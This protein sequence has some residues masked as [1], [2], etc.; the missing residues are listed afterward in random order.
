MLREKFLHLGLSAKKKQNPFIVKA[1]QT[2]SSDD[3]LYIQLE[4]VKGCDLIGQIRMNNRVVKK[5]FT[6]YAAEVLCALE[7]LHNLNV[8]YRDLKPEHVL[9]DEAGHCKLIDFGFGKQLKNQ[10]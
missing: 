7:H 6:F 5:S 10:S 8:V 9:I 2:F 1:F 4:F 3:K